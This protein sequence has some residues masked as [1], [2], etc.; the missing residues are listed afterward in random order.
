ME[1]SF[2]GVVAGKVFRATEQTQQCTQANLFKAAQCIQLTNALLSTTN[3]NQVPSFLL[4]FKYLSIHLQLCV[5]F[6]KLT[7][8]D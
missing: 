5:T 8:Q 7:L 4:T 2:N 1:G 6:W 3:R